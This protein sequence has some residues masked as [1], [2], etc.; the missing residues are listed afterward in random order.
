MEKYAQSRWHQVVLPPVIHP[1][2]V[3][4]VKALR[5]IP[6][7]SPMDQTRVLG[8][9]PELRGL[10][11]LLDTCLERYPE[12][13]MGKV[14]PLSIL[15]P[16]GSMAL[17]EGAYRDNPVADYCNKVVADIVRRYVHLRSTT[18]TRIIEIGAGTGATTQF[19]LP[20]V[21]NADV[22][23]VFTDL[24]PAFLNKAK[25]RFADHKFVSYGVYNI[26]KKPEFDRPFDI[27]IA[28]NVLHATVYVSNALKN[29]RDILASDGILVVNEFTARRDYA[30]LTFGLT[31]GWW[32]N[33]DGQRIEHSP[34]LTGEALRSLIRGARFSS[35]ASHGN[36]EQQ[37]IVATGSLGID[38]CYNEGSD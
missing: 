20:V 19:V 35:V 28:A 29:A 8:Q 5:A 15:F 10:M 38:D 9:Y 31:E 2:F 3:K 34:L 11:K 14:D 32:M 13:L 23:Y 6:Y 7:V 25:R 12:I 37:V 16:G 30:T 26:E 17:V 18:N 1:R 24:S 36:E 22:E 33:M 21:C 4:L 27:L